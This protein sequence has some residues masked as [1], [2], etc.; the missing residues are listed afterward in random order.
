[1]TFQ[2]AV[3]YITTEINK[4]SNMQLVYISNIAYSV[5]GE[6]E[7]YC[8]EHKKTHQLSREDVYTISKK[9]AKHYLYSW[10]LNTDK[11]G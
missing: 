7:R 6:F 10:L 4:D 1:M 9:A 11:E 5:Q 8:M 3:K 2:E